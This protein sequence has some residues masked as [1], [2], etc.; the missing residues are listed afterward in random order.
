[1]SPLRSRRRLS[2]CAQACRGIPTEVLEAGGLDEVLKLARAALR[3]QQSIEQ[4]DLVL[5]RR[6]LATIEEH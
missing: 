2:I 3:L 5:V 6:V 1:M 4:V